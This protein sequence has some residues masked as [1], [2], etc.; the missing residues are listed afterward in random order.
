MLRKLHI[1][2]FAIIDDLELTFSAGLNILTGETGAGKSIILDSLGLLMGQRALP[3]WIRTGAQ[4]AWVE[5]ICELPPLDAPA[6]SATTVVVHRTIRA[7]GRSMCRINGEICSREAMQ[8]TMRPLIEIHGQ[9][10]HLRLMDTSSHLQL[11]DRFA[12][13]QSSQAALA[14]KVQDLRQV[15]QQLSQTQTD[16]RTLMQRMDML[17][18]QVAEIREAAIQPAEE[19]IL[20]REQIRLGNA[21]KL[22]ELAHACKGQLEAGD[23]EVPS[24]L[25]MLGEVQSS[26]L[27]LAQIDTSQAAQA[28]TLQQAIDLIHGTCRDMEDYLDSLEQDPV[29][30]QQVEERI[31][32][33]TTLKKKYG[34]TLEDILAF[35]QRAESELHDLDNHEDRMARLQTQETALL[36]QIAVDC[37]RLSAARQQ[38]SR[39]LEAQIEQHLA[40]LFPHPTHFEVVLGTEEI[41]NG[42]PLPDGS[43]VQFNHT[44]ID[45]VSFL[46]STNPGEPPKPL[47]EVASGGETA[48]LMLATKSVLAESGSPPTLIFDEIDQGIGGRM[49]MV[50]GSKLWHLAH[51]AA[52][53]PSNSPERQILC[54]T[55]LAQL[56]V[57]GDTHFAVRKE[58]KQQRT[59]TLVHL[60]P[61]ASRIEELALMQG[62]PSAQG[63]KSV[64][65]LIQQAQRAQQEIA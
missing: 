23:A 20:R 13:L 9:S 33:L 2:N 34:P 29:Q 21:E 38:A 52:C 65:E 58:V 50:V 51:P 37:L 55:H 18:F 40:D 16:T 43:C 53:G 30:L 11:L 8:A 28:D 63:R 60:L 44:G 19:D 4:E 17:R 56:A 61:P 22:G 1:H 26:L 24:I 10:D 25:D 35:R 27:Q 32:L 31:T 39:R 47:V 59:R 36:D 7:S 12:N 3:S 64:Q 48:R 62:N 45:Q 42:L 6:A 46:V 54:V 15:R 14:Q 5:A 57:F 41:P 49:G